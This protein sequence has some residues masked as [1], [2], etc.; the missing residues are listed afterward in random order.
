MNAEPRKQLT[1]NLITADDVHDELTRVARR[2]E[3]RRRLIGERK[4]A[5]IDQRIDRLFPKHPNQEK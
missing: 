2:C 4:Q 3:Q 5:L 1:F